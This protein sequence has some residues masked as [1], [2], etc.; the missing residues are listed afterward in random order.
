LHQL[1]RTTEGFWFD[2]QHNII[3]IQTQGSVD[4]QVEIRLKG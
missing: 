1:R 2:S 4:R 3:Y